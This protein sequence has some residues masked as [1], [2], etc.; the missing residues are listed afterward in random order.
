MEGQLLAA[1]LAVASLLETSRQPPSAQVELWVRADPDGFS[2]VKDE[3]LGVDLTA[4]RHS[5]GS[6]T[7]TGRAGGPFSLDVRREQVMD[8]D[9]SVSRWRLTDGA[10]AWTLERVSRNRAD[11]RLRPA[12]GG[13]SVL[14]AAETGSEG[15]EFRVEADGLALRTRAQGSR[16]RVGG[17]AAALG[18]RP[19]ALLGAALVLLRL[20]PPLRYGG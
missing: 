12:E 19:A 17:N 15:P 1:A 7:F 6:W 9:E 8:A 14:F 18:P 4:M 20:D 5:P 16:T 13:P 3:A 10:A 2:S 11:Y